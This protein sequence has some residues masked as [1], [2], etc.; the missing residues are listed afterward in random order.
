[1]MTIDHL[2][3]I[4]SEL[5]SFNSDV[6]TKI[7][8]TTKFAEIEMNSLDVLEFVMTLEDEYKIEISDEDADSFRTFGDVL[9]YLNKVKE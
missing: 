6:T 4:L 1:M 8:E 7:V 2:K 5:M 9:A 3:L